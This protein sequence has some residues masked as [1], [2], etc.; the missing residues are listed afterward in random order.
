MFTKTSA[1]LT[2]QE[3]QKILG[4]F[5]SINSH[6]SN[7]ILNKTLIQQALLLLAQFSDYQILGICADTLAQGYLAL[8]TYTAAL[9]YEAALDVDSVAG[10]VYLK[11]NSQT[12]LCRLDSRSGKY[13]GVLVS[14]QSSHLGGVNEMYGHLPLDLFVSIS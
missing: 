13:H 2:I 6:P 7:S 4:A 3:A 14:Y 1:N 10:P 12:G 5:N 11:F 9:G 8:K